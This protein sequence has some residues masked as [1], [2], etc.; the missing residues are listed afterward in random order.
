MSSIIK[1]TKYLRFNKISSIHKKTY[2]IHIINISSN[3]IIGIIKWYTAW[4][5]YCFYPYPDTIWNKDCLES[6]NEVIISLMEERKPNKNAT[7][8]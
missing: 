2:I 3:R 7:T 8:N 6:V 5:Q 4:R 1:E